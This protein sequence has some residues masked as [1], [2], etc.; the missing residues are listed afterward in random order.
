MRLVVA[1]LLTDP[2]FQERFFADGPERAEAHGLTRAEAETLL[3]LDRRKL[4][5]TCEGYSG[6]RLERVMTVMPLA[7]AALERSASDGALRYLASTRHA[8]SEDAEAEAFLAFLRHSAL[9]DPDARRFLVDLARVERALHARTRPK[10]PPA[11]RYRPEL[12]RPK[13]T[14]HAPIVR[15]EGAL[16][17]GLGS[18][19]TI[20][21]TY[22]H[23]PQAALVLPRRGGVRVE[24]LTDAKARLLEACDGTR[25]VGQ[26]VAALGP[27]AEPVLAQWLALQVVHDAAETSL[28][29]P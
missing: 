23:A 2:S 13:A 16:G 1:R 19:P 18:P 3:S 15:L 4:A 25:T 20:P 7:L 8:T 12:V 22:P 10:A 27:E 14:G 6:K 26:L 28:T 9:P 17:E 5:I 21:P 24:E 11:Y 29:S